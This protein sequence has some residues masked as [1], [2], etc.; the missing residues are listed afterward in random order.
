MRPRILW[1][2]IALAV[3]GV[4][5]APLGKVQVSSDACPAG[6]GPVARTDCRVLVVSCPGLK[7]LRAQVRITEP[8]ADKQ[9]R[10]TVVL[11]SGGNGAGFY[12]GQEGG[13]TLVR[14]LAAM[15][16]RVVDRAWDGGWPTQEGGLKKEAC[17]YATLLTWIHSRV[18]TGGKFAATGNSGGSAEI[19]YALTTYGRSAILDVAIPTSGPPVARLDYAC[20]T[21]AS[22]E[23]AALCSSIVPRGVMECV[24]G[25]VLGPNNG[26]CKQVGPQPTAAQLL[27]DSVVHP[28]AVLDYPKTKLYFLFGALDCGEP[29]PVGLTFATKVTS[30]K[31]ILFVPRTPHALFSTVEGREAIRN[32]LDEGTAQAANPAAPREQQPKPSP[33]QAA[34]QQ[35]FRRRTMELLTPEQRAYLQAN[36]KVNRQVWIQEHPAR[37]S[38][39]LIPLPDLGKRTYKGEE[40]GLYPGGENSPPPEHLRTGQAQAPKIVPL[41]AAGRP[42]PDGKVVMISVGMSNTTMKFQT[43]QKMAAEDGSLNPKLVLVDGAQGGQVAWVTA[44]PQMPFWE[45]VDRRLQAAGVTRNQVQAAWILQANPGPTRLFPA[46][47]KELQ[48]NLADTL[49]VMQDRFPNLKIAYLSSRTYAGYAT[50]PLNPEPFAYESGFSVKGL[51]ADQIAGNS[52]LNYDPGKGP[53]RAPWVAWG[54]YVWADGV[55]GNKEGLSY[56][57]EDYTEQDGTHPS[58]SGRAKVATRLLQFLKSD[59]TSKPWFMR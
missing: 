34:E 12:G 40:G 51:I 35:E 14:E 48:R 22:P 28:A 36:G 23:W 26:I 10:G 33:A 41:D 15:G 52:E 2:A 53:V 24:P 32:A 49:H 3:P 21:Q 50:S 11:G 38:T 17:R 25:C 57:R 13:Q 29:V 8:A 56:A 4:A 42:S 16:F 20:V 5:A 39:G 47:A 1:M 43:F 19:G 46:E 18:H 7:D 54:P 31:V 44:N 6:A 45:V 37:Q 9:V 30:E 58:P 27:D 59:S 55:Q